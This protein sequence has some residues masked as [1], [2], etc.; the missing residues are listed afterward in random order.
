MR[1]NESDT[2]LMTNSEQTS[3]I[4]DYDE[5]QSHCPRLGHIIHFGYCRSCQN[6]LPCFKI[7]DC[8][9]MQVPIEEFLTTHFNAD[10]I[11]NIL[12]PPKPK[13]LS[14]LELIEAAKK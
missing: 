6:K 10:E 5:H 8:W 9:Y 12:S 14:I 7:M 4:N 3:R 2:L 13:L 11:Q 1:I